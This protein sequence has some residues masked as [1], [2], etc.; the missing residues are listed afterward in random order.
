MTKTREG[1]YFLE[2]H[3][4]YWALVPTPA[5][6]PRVTLVAR[7]LPLLL[8]GMERLIHNTALGL[9]DQVELTVIGPLG[10]ANHLPT[11]AAEFN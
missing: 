9:A 10:C 6:K 2:K 7:N 1:E 3:V 4:S 5:P 8:G 11:H